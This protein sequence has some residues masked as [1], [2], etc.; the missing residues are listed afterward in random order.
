[1]NDTGLQH[2]I[3]QLEDRERKIISNL[4]HR[5]TISKDVNQAFVEQLSFGQRTAD[6][7]AAFGGSWTFIFCFLA[8]MATWIGVNLM[9]IRRF[10][11]YPFILLNLIL[12]CL[13]ALQAPVIMMSQNR[14]AANDRL[15]AQHD[16]EINLKAEMEI[17]AL[18]EKIDE[19]REIRWATLISLQQEQIGLLQSIHTHLRSRPSHNE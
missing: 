16:Y 10:D 13:A 2:L 17:M 8:V 19:L 5:R 6:R 3:A 9:G 4:L 11:P 15:A 12:S 18:H 14:Q 1:M 7:V